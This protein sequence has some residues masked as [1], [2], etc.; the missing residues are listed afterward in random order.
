MS[1]KKIEAKKQAYQSIVQTAE[2]DG[3]NPV[4]VMEASLNIVAFET[5]QRLAGRE[6]VYDTSKCHA[7]YRRDLAELGY[8]FGPVGDDTIYR[9]HDTETT[10]VDVKR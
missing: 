9:R 4:D 8:F 3:N 6:K 5:L 2:Q 10:I 1:Q 7:D